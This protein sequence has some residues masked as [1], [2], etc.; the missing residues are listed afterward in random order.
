MTSVLPSFDSSHQN[1]ANPGI[2]FDCKGEKGLSS[3]PEVKIYC[4]EAVT[5]SRV[6]GRG[7][8]VYVQWGLLSAETA[9]LWAKIGNL[10]RLGCFDFCGMAWV[11]HRLNL[12]TGYNF[13]S[14]NVPVQSLQK[15]LDGEDNVMNC[16]RYFLDRTEN[17]LKIQGCK[18]RNLF[19]YFG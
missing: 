5:W 1:R 16:N 12:E 17:S 3:P 13:D 4:R 9:I 6:G 10:L 18:V 19:I 14:R 7:F 8:L 2:L 11:Y 15:T